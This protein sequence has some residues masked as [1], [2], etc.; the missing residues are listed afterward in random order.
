MQYGDCAI[1]ASFAQ[2]IGELDAA[3]V[4]C[5]IGRFSTILDHFGAF[6]ISGT[7]FVQQI[8]RQSTSIYNLFKVDTAAASYPLSHKVPSAISGR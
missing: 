8:Y 2:C 7:W 1:A 4:K 6:I 5:I 3:T